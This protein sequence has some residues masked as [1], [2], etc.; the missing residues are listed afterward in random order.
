[1]PLVES[2]VWDLRVVSR[3]RDVGRRQG[4]RLDNTLAGELDRLDGLDGGRSRPERPRFVAIRRRLAWRR[5]VGGR[6]RTARTWSTSPPHDVHQ[7]PQL[8]VDILLARYS[9]GYRLAERV[10]KL[11]PEPMDRHPER[12]LT[13]VQ[14]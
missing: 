3:L 1:M 13:G 14:L 4:T 10:R 9:L 2:A 8:V 7:V 6:T 12:A 11:F 5:I